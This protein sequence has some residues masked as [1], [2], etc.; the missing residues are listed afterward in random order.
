MGDRIYVNFVKYEFEES[1]NK[2]KSQLSK[3][4]PIEILDEKLIEKEE[5]VTKKDISNTETQ[6]SPPNPIQYQL[7]NIVCW[8]DDEV[9]A[10]FEDMNCLKLYE[11]LK[12]CNGE[13][14]KQLHEIWIHAPE[15]FYQFISLDNKLDRHTLLL[16][17]NNLQKAFKQ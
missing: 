11:S 1:I 7:N 12:P 9:K 4:M 15:F 5:I 10:W 8:S 2:L 13:L 6:E 3:I 16:F 17:S 14:L